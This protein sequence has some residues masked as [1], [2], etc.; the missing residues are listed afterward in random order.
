MGLGDI[1]FRLCYSTVNLFS[2]SPPSL[3][4]VKI[5]FAALEAKWMRTWEM[6]KQLSDVQFRPPIHA[7]TTTTSK[8]VLAM[9]PYPSG[10]LHMGHVRV[11]TIADCI[12]RW[13]KLLGENVR[14]WHR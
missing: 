3:A 7:N 11:Y 13:R 10:R 14:H 9:F 8:M 4:H 2:K 5:D 1:Q 12:A 6:Q